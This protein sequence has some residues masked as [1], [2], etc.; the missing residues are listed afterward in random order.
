MG[1]VKRRIVQSGYMSLSL[2]AFHTNFSH[3]QVYGGR[4]SG[5]RKKE[6]ERKKDSE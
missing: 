6:Q 2:E 3:R 1:K 4:N 5:M